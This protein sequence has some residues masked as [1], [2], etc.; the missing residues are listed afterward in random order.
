[1]NSK[2]N[3]CINIF[4]TTK[5]KKLTLHIHYTTINFK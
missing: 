1:M 4:I 2:P 5:I 3:F